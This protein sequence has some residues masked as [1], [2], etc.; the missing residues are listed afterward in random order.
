[1]PQ[2]EDFGGKDAFRWASVDHE[3]WEV[4]RFWQHYVEKMKK[5]DEDESERPSESFKM[6]A[7]RY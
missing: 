1:M 6:K 7:D 2:T 4:D 3:D 5:E